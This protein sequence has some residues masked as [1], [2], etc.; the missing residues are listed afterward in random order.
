[1]LSPSSK[2]LIFKIDIISC[3]GQQ[4][5]KDTELGASDL[6]DIWTLTLGRGLD[7][8]SGYSTTKPKGRDIRV[9]YQLKQ[10][11]SVRDIAK[12]QE[13][14]HERSSIFSTDI[15]KC[16]VIGLNEVR[17]AN[18]GE[19]VKVTVNKPNFDITPEQVV[20]WMSKYGKVKEGHR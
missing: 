14:T 4:I 3:N 10:P 9:Q 8:I 19:M 7:E 17:K 5:A 13:F 20:E 11:M 12:E 1:M 15:F 18:I 2:I 16:R 6:E